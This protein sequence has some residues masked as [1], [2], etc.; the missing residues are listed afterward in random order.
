MRCLPGPQPTDS[1]AHGGKACSLCQAQPAAIAAANSSSGPSGS[2]QQPAGRG[3]G[4]SCYYRA[5]GGHNKHR[6]GTGGRCVHTAWEASSPAGTAPATCL[7]T[8]SCPIACMHAPTN[9][10][11]S[12]IAAHSPRLPLSRRSRL[13]EWWCCLWCLASSACV[14]CAMSGSSMRWSTASRRAPA[15]TATCSA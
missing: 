14:V 1:S 12:P 6:T 3:S 4:C 5:W 15:R 11:L 7:L 8:F 13:R 9:L 10:P 2:L